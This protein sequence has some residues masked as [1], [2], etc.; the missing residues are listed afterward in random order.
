MIILGYILII[1]S[2]LLLMS[3]AIV[4]FLRQRLS[5]VVFFGVAGYAII[6]AINTGNLVRQF[7]EETYLKMSII[8]MIGSGILT[9]SVLIFSKLVP[10][11]NLSLPIWNESD[12]NRHANISTS[13]ALISVVLIIIDR[14]D[15]LLM[16][17][18]D[19]RASSGYL[20]A[21]ATFFFMLASP[22]IISA[23]KANRLAL[24]IVLLLVCICL[25][26]VIGARS[27]LLCA[28]FFGVW[29][30]LSRARGI[31]SR[32]RIIT[33]AV[34]VALAVHTFLR[35]LRG[36]GMGGLLQAFEEGK[37]WT[38][39]FAFVMDDETS[40]TGGESEIAELLM[41]SITQ[42]SISDFGFMTSIQR[43]I[44]LPI[45]SIDGLFSKPLDV[46][47]ILW[48]RAF[49]EGLFDGAQ[50]QEVL[51]ESYLTGSLGSWH[52]T[53]FGEY[54][55]SGGWIS[56]VL[57]VAI[58][59]AI[60]VAIDFFMHRADRLTS[61]ALCGPLLVGYLFVSRGNSVIGLGYFVYL[62][63][64]FGLL[65]YAVYCVEKLRRKIKI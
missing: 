39:L 58:L 36:Y 6:A 31:G 1:G 61:L 13:L 43:V 8:Y 47:N 5:S 64:L 28:L 51:L 24:A 20:T 4:G 65:S 52:P 21:L 54:F 35:T 23:F 45:P 25:F 30:I 34:V 14:G 11:R 42:S 60:L 53:L 56:L 38:T 55:L 46:T 44:L 37:L 59:G 2:A 10:A 27:S 9:I 62:G 7:G 32:V 3:M 22:G 57:S 49:E 29:L 26:V 50:G 48:R 15:N 33:I 18:G 19:V 63:V 40:V 12:L 17:W 41:F 16:S